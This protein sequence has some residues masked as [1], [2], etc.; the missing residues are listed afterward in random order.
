MQSPNV[1]FMY[2]VHRC[3]SG[4]TRF[5]LMNYLRNPWKDHN[6]VRGFL[7]AKMSLP[8]SQVLCFMRACTEN[9]RAR[10]A[11]VTSRIVQPHGLLHEFTQIQLHV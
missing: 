4:I 3:K 1:I 5:L 10:M 11:C 7:I 9:V 8:S 6:V 2:C